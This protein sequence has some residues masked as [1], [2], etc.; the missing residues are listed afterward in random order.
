MRENN[1][2]R[3]LHTDDVIQVRSGK[4]RTLWSDL[5]RLVEWCRVN[6]PAAWLL[7]L[8]VCLLTVL[9]TSM[10]AENAVRLCTP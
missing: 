6:A 9:Y 1:L 4:H 7:V 8:L 10:L 5:A 2:A 3:Y